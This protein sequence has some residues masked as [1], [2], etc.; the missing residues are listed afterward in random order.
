MAEMAAR[1]VIN[2]QPMRRIGNDLKIQLTTKKALL[3]LTACL[4]LFTVWQFMIAASSNWEVVIR[5]NSSSPLS[6]FILGYNRGTTRTKVSSI[7]ANSTKS[8]TIE[9]KSEWGLRFKFYTLDGTEYGDLIPIYYP[10]SRDR[11]IF[12]DIDPNYKATW[13]E[14]QRY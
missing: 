14:S 5:N 1:Q 7:P 9:L 10:T 8:L 4:L 11:K 13:H 3:I 6:N 12:I 2:G